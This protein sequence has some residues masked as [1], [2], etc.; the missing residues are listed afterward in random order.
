[1]LLPGLLKTKSSWSRK[2]NTQ[3]QESIPAQLDFAKRNGVKVIRD[4]PKQ[5][6]PGKVIAIP[7][8]F[9]QLTFT[10]VDLDRMR[11]SYVR[12]AVTRSKVAKV[13]QEE[14]KFLA[15]D[16]NSSADFVVS[17]LETLGVQA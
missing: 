1:M 10:E 16:T 17:V 12:N 2:L 7:E 3:G 9:S 14:V 4:E 5:N 6:V 13:T 15:E 11:T 8:H